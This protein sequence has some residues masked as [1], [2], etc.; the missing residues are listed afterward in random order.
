MIN[1]RMAIDIFCFLGVFLGQRER[2]RVGED[3]GCGGGVTCSRG[4]TARFKS[5]KLYFIWSRAVTVS[6]VIC[7]S[8][9]F[10]TKTPK[11]CI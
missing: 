6:R 1:G 4:V 8:V 11:I 9:T 5:G 7:Y 2:Q 10:Q 3:G